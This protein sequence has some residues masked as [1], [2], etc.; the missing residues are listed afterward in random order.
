M[1]VSADDARAARWTWML[2]SRGFR[3]GRR[4]AG[5]LGLVLAADS[6]TVVVID[7]V[8]PAEDLRAIAEATRADPGPAVLVIGPVEPNVHAMVAIATGALGYLAACSA[9]DA[10]ADAVEAMERGEAVLPRAVS[11]PLVQHLRCGGR[12]L[13]ITGRDGRLAK[14]TGREW[15][16]LVLLRQGMTTTQIAR[17]LF[18]SAGTIRTHVAALVHKLGATDRATLVGLPQSVA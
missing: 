4:P 14:L 2:R 7:G 15:E 10:V 3:I 12:G 1:I 11:I 17:Q 5:S 16:V 13:E 18:V 8:P 9:D 6:P